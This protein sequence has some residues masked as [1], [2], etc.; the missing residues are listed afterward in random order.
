M[1]GIVR[2][3]AATASESLTT[4]LQETLVFKVRNAFFELRSDVDAEHRTPE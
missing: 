1:C 2:W 4:I 3:I